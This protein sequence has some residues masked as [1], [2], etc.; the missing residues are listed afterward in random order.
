MSPANYPL[1][2]FGGVTLKTCRWVKIILNFF[3]YNLLS[4]GMDAGV[5][6]NNTGR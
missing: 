1:T 5:T 4:T 6:E 2:Y 3:N